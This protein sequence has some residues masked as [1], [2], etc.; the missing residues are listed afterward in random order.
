MEKYT[1]HHRQHF[2][3]G[4]VCLQ[5]KAATT[6][7]AFVR[8]QIFYRAERIETGAMPSRKSQQL[9]RE[10]SC[11]PPIVKPKCTIAHYPSFKLGKHSR[12]I[13]PNVDLHANI[14]STS[15]FILIIYIY[16][17]NDKC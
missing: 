15:T 6:N 3:A 5:K 12:Y 7:S 9:F 1:E 11:I 17:F 10:T 16:T 13:Q 14:N 8:P 4:V 2:Q